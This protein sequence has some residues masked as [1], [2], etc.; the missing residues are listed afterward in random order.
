MTNQFSP[1]PVSLRGAIMLLGSLYWEGE[2]PAVD[3]DKGEKRKLWR[4]KHLDMS[5][6]RELPGIP[7]RYGRQS[8]S[9]N[10]EFTIVFG[11]KPEGIAKVANLKSELTTENG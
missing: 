2:K 8:A 10:D 7:I 5:S 6:C 11:G 9:R 4:D 3:G 1:K